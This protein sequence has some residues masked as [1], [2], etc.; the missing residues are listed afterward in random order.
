[1]KLFIGCF[2]EL[3][4]G[5]SPEIIGFSKTTVLDEMKKRHPPHFG[6]NWQKVDNAYQNGCDQIVIQEVKIADS[7]IRCRLAKGCR[8]AQ[9]FARRQVV[10][11][12]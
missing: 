2:G 10:A 12:D 4:E 11:L 1:M 9:E 3:C 7:I 6:D 5:H 8:S